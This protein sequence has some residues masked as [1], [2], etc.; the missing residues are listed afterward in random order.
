M[1]H[2]PNLVEVRKLHINGKPLFATLIDYKGKET[3][4]L[5]TSSTFSGT[6]E[7]IKGLVAIK[8]EV[9]VFK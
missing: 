5:A 8:D 1:F 9:N 7:N 3:R 2:V 6:K 4:V